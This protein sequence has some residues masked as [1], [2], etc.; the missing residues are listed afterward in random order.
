[1][2][3][4]V[5]NIRAATRQATGIIAAGYHGTRPV[6]VEAR[7]HPGRTHLGIVNS[8]PYYRQPIGVHCVKNANT[9][10]PS[11]PAR[12]SAAA[13]DSH[14]Y[15]LFV[16]LFVDSIAV[17][18]QLCARFVTRPS[19]HPPHYGELLVGPPT[20]QRTSTAAA[21][22]DGRSKNLGQA[23]GRWVQRLSHGARRRQNAFPVSSQNRSRPP[24]T[25]V[26]FVTDWSTLTSRQKRFRQK[27]EG[28][29]LSVIGA[30]WN[31]F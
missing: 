21:L 29:S 15:L 30:R 5:T 31:R 10:N 9:N 17:L 22:R 12:W 19:Q 11:L 4:I 3:E 13:D 24:S 20:A 18:C 6:E 14:R 28:W 7:E 25:N 1:M 27:T 2:T 8:G 16:L 26:S 23:P